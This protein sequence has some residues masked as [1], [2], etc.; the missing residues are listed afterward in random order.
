M[1]LIVGSAYEFTYFVSEWNGNAVFKRLEKPL[2]NGL[3]TY[4]SPDR[5]HYYKQRTDGL[6][7]FDPSAAPTLETTEEFI[8]RHGPLFQ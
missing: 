5:R 8:R 6:W 7:E 2:T 3:R 1:E 4:V